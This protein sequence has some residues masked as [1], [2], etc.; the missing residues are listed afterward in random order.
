MRLYSLKTYDL[1]RYST[2]QAYVQKVHGNLL[3]C[4]L[5]LLKH[6]ES[7]TESFLFFWLEAPASSFL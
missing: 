6:N 4:V 7:S 1:S 3:F 5:I 2:T